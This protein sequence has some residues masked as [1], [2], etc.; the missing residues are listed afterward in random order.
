M[1]LFLL[2]INPVTWM[3]PIF[4]ALWSRNIWLIFLAG[5]LGSVLT[6]F[7][8]NINESEGVVLPLGYGVAVIIGLV[9]GGLVVAVSKYIK[10]LLAKF[11]NKIKILGWES[12]FGKT[13][14]VLITILLFAYFLSGLLA[15]FIHTKLALNSDMILLSFYASWMEDVIFFSVVGLGVLLLTFKQPEHEPF[16]NRVK[17]LY[18]T[19]DEALID[20]YSKEIENLAI[21]QTY[22]KRDIYIEQY[23]QDINSCRLRVKSQYNFKSILDVKHDESIPMTIGVDEISS[24]PRGGIGCVESIKVDGSDILQESGVQSIH[25]ESGFKTKLRL[26]FEP[27]GTINVETNHWIWCLIGVNQYLRVTR[28]VKLFEASFTNLCPDIVL[29]LTSSEDEGNERTLISKQ[30]VDLNP[31]YSVIPGEIAYEIKLLSPE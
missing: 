15:T 25:P 31:K 19:E 12:K 4:I 2:I 9:V 1:S 28:F 11:G 20:Y 6:T 8:H 13:S 21:Y 22:A 29:R 27:N 18:K 17:I 3:P 30:T 24:I 16:R 10:Y 14:L 23:D 26:Y 7:I 5:V